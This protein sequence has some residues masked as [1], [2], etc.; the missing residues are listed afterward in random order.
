VKVKV[1]DKELASETVAVEQWSDLKVE[2]PDSRGQRVVMELIVPEGQK[3]SE[4]VWIDYFDF[5]DN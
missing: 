5:F 2:V 3:W 4:G 1:G